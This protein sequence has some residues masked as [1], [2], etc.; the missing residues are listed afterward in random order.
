MHQIMNIK[1]NAWRVFILSFI[2]NSCIFDT[3]P[4]GYCVKNCTDDTLLINITK[5][6]TLGNEM[7]WYKGYED[8]VGNVFPEDTIMFQVHGKKVAVFTYSYILP[9]SS[10]AFWPQL[11]AKDTCYVYAIKWHDVTTYPLENIRAKKLYDRC[12]VTNKDFQNRI[13]EYR[14]SNFDRDN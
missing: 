1:T 6:D 9:D 14:Y 13:F 4:L 3:M 7:Y 12:T 10:L 11:N 2:F 5:T 8:S